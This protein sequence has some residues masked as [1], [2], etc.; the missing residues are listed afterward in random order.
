M[1]CLINPSIAG[2]EGAKDINGGNANIV[3]AH[4]HTR[5]ISFCNITEQENNYYLVLSENILLRCSGTVE[6]LIGQ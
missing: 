6:I 5:R 2:G 1:E 4:C 3:Q